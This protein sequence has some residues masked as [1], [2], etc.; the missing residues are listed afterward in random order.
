MLRLWMK[1]AKEND[2]GA[3]YDLNNLPVLDRIY[4]YRSFDGNMYKEIEMKCAMLTEMYLHRGWETDWN[5]LDMITR[6]ER[7]KRLMEV[8][9]RILQIPEIEVSV[10]PNLKFENQ[11]VDGLAGFDNKVTFRKIS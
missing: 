11:I 3:L 8:A 10:I 9:C 1:A 6:E 2:T 7:C 5:K 4:S